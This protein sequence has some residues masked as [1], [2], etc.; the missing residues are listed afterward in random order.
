MDS[1]DQDQDDSSMDHDQEEKNPKYSEDKEEDPDFEVKT[2][3][4]EYSDDEGSNFSDEFLAAGSSAKSLRN[5]GRSS[6]KTDN[7]P[8]DSSS[9]TFQYGPFQR[10]RWQKIEL[11]EEEI[12]RNWRV[13]CTTSQKNGT[14]VQYYC[15]HG[16]NCRVRVKIKTLKNGAV[17]MTTNG[18]EHTNHR[19]K[20][21]GLTLE[22][23][24]FV[25]ECLKL[26]VNR[27]NNIMVSFRAKGIPAP[28]KKQLCCWLDRVRRREKE[29]NKAGKGQ[30]QTEGQK[31]KEDEV[32]T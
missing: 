17:T 10:I 11:S 1:T 7:T 18:R 32:K 5:S 2:E 8:K 15:A 26:G 14:I 12:Q 27:P 19:D 23:K 24:Q 29:K 30:E 22:Q 21:F 9:S 20:N 25:E 16:K 4:Q 31:E 28:R 6:T 3:P 13:Q